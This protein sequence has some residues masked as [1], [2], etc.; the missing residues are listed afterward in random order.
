MYLREL[1][2]LDGRAGDMGCV[3][4]VCSAE[5][6]DFRCEDCFGGEMLCQGCMVEI[7][8]CMPLHRIEVRNLNSSRPHTHPVLNL[9]ALERAIF[10]VIDVEKDWVAHSARTSNW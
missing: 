6:P 9:I 10:R 7:H 5:G 1:L 8:A 4:T 2:R 3:C